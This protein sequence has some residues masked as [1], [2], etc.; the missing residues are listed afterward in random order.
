MAAILAR[1]TALFGPSIPPRP[2]T[3]PRLTSWI[4]SPTPAAPGC[5]SAIPKATPPPTS[6]AR[7]MRM[8]GYNVLHPMG[9]DAFGLPAEQ[10]AIKQ[11]RPPA[12]HHRA[13]HRQLP[14]ADPDARP[15][16]RL[17]PRNRHHRSA[18]ITAGPSGSS[19]NS[20][21]AISIR[22]EQPAKPIQRSAQSNC[23]TDN[24][25]VGPD[26]SVHVN[27]TSQE[28]PGRHRRRSPHR[29]PLARADR[30]RAAAK[31]SPT[32]A[33]PTWTKSPSTGA[34]ASGTVLANEEVIDGKSEVGG[35]PVDRQPMR[36]WM[37]RITAYADRLLDDLEK[38][39]WPES[40]KE[41]QRN[42]IGKSVG[43]E[44]DFEIDR[45]HRRA[46]CPASPSSPPAPTRCT[47]RPTWSSPPSI[48]WS[49]RSP[50][51]PTRMPSRPI[52]QI[53]RRQAE[54]DRMAETKDKT[55][56][57][58]GALCH[59]PRQRRK[60]PDLDRRLRADGLR[61]RRDHGRARPR[62]ARF[63]ICH[64]IQTCR[65][66]RS[67]SPAD[68]HAASPADACLRRAKASRSIS[69]ASMACPPPRPRS[70]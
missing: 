1:R 10:Y 48:R 67:S 17:G 29:A 34:P 8:K 6:S 37:L 40:L 26:G 28:R 42:W 32:S 47:A 52:A 18:T 50:P 44:V 25:V 55:G 3:C 57:F 59:Q 69:L 4:C 19:C 53:R 13:K 56:V 46:E 5:T 38:L 22:R 58:T 27:P 62:P 30:N 12:H 65:S 66:A 35:F 49:T 63:R 31:S 20:S 21:T 39:E 14:P 7:Y 36:Q 54:R 61:H 2:A 68:G 9:W 33:W 45:Q 15:Q 70:T 11:Q 23:K 43:A 41:M 16:L 24:L 64:E 60:D 51:R